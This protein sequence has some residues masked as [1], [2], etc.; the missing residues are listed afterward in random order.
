MI[1][2]TK[3]DILFIEVQN[4]S[5]N[6]IIEIPPRKPFVQRFFIELTQNWVEFRCGT[7][8]GTIPNQ[9]L[10]GLNFLVK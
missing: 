7:R 6:K 4:F 8:F 5:S 3:K 10:L 1:T 2:M 9:S